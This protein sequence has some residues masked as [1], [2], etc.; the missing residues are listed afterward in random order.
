MLIEAQS[1]PLPAPD[2]LLGQARIWR[3]IFHPQGRLRD[4]TQAWQLCIAQK[5]PEAS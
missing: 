4:F 3:Q 1:T 2:D 5:L